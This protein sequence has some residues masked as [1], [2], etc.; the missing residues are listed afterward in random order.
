MLKGKIIPY[1]N[2]IQIMVPLNDLK[3]HVKCRWTRLFLNDTLHKNNPYSI[4]L[5]QISSS[6]DLFINPSD[7][8]TNPYKK[9]CQFVKV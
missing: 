1:L 8:I 3:S 2:C 6:S 9:N 5:E 4:F 7:R